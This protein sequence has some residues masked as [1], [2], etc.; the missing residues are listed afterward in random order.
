MAEIVRAGIVS[1]DPG[2]LEAGASVGLT[3]A[4]TMRVIVLPQ[5]MRAIIPPTGNQFIGMLKN[6]SLV[7]VIAVSE[8]LTTVQNIYSMNYL[9]IELLIVA[10][11]WYLVV[12]ALATAGQF[13]VERYFTQGDRNRA[14]TPIQKTTRLVRKPCPERWRT[15]TG[16]NTTDAWNRR[17]SPSLEKIRHQ[18]CATRSVSFGATR[19]SGLPIGAIGLGQ[20]HAPSVHKQSRNYRRRPYLG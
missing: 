10:A 14:L 4:K 2:Q 19:G 12:T 3:R 20:E 13:Y 5:A 7:S 9:V 8:L 16:W 11:I 17:G 1:V 6:S 15:T 18:C